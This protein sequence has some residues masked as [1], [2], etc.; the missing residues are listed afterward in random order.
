MNSAPSYRPQPPAG[1]AW[2]VGRNGTIALAVVGLHVGVLWALQN[3]LL[4]R[5]AERVVPVALIGQWVTPPAATP[6][7]PQP[8]AAPAAPV[9]GKRKPAVPAARPS[10]SP[11][12]L[13]ITDSA[14]APVPAPAAAERSNPGSTAAAPAVTAPPV[15]T[16]GSA[17]AAATAAVV[18]LPSS[19]ADY[20]QNP[21]PP[22]PPLSERLGEQGNVIYKVWIGTD[23]RAQRAELVSSSGFARLDKA[24]YDTVMRWRYVPGKRNGVP[25]AMAFNVPIRWQLRGSP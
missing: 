9:T 14:P 6:A 24:A 1:R 20:L 10:T 7:P 25:E 23:G 22:Y 19:D 12:P 8:A 4:M 11:Q 15:A 5:T 18:Q 13:A 17:S 16:T 3:G 2:P 21:K